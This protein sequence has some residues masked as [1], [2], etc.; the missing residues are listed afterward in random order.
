MADDAR[1][2]FAVMS[3]LL[4]GGMSSRL[5]YEIR[6]KRGLVY[7][8]HSFLSQFSETGM[9]GVYAGTGA[10]EAN[11]VLRLIGE[12]MARARDGVDEDETA[13]AKA[14]LR[15]GALMSR[16]SVES[17]CDQLAH[18]IAVHGRPIPMEERMASLAA[19]D[20]AAARGALDQLLNGPLTLALVGPTSGVS[21]FE[22]LTRQLTDR[23]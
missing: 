14:Q 19:V 4:G 22:A 13:R 9:F 23:G 16:E 10:N 1:Y 12:E 8:V 7:G 20:A 5:F 21:D 6:E 15:A 2:A 18:E 17:R 3:T 11:A